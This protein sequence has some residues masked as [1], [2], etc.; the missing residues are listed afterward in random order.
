MK[1]ITRHLQH[2]LPLLGILVAGLV[3]IITFSYDTNFQMALLF[4]TASGYVSWGIVHHY[5]HGDLH[6]S[7]IFE[8]IVIALLGV[9]I[10][11]SILLRV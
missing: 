3:G 2:Y 4:A 6:S 11:S 8:Y 7:I 5:I 9:V 10:V 1:R